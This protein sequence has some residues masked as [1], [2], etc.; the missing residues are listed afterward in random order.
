[1][2]QQASSSP[3]DG[4]IVVSDPPLGLP[5]EEMQY[6]LLEEQDTLETPLLVRGTEDL[7]HPVEEEEDRSTGRQWLTHILRQSTLALRP[8]VRATTYQSCGWL[9]SILLGLA[10]LVL[11]HWH[12][13]RATDYPAN[14]FENVLHCASKI[15]G[16]VEDV[17]SAA[18][19]AVVW[20]LEEGVDVQ[21][22]D[23]GA[24][25]QTLFALMVVSESMGLVGWD[26]E[27]TNREDACGWP[28]VTCEGGEITELSL[29]HANVT[30]T[31]PPELR[32][33]TD[34]KSLKLFSN[35]HLVGHIPSAL[36]EMTNLE[37]LDLQETSIGGSPTAGTWP[38]GASQRT[39][40]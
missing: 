8:V 35:P 24:D 21:V 10:V 28:R 34:L 26:G 4:A 5:S 6:H 36:G 18:Y 2:I 29:G 19:N 17:H 7:A 11:L 30:G 12:Q 9:L 40:D 13:P 16:H 33:L 22:E 38:F 23:C 3:Q 25:F 27:V 39:L 37:Q 31:L 14:R 15:S 32:G 1:M 20:F